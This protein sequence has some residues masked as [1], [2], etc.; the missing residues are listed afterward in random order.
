[1]YKFSIASIIKNESPY[2]LEWIAYHL[3]IGVEHFY[4]ADNCSDDGQYQ[5]LEALQ[6]LGIVTL[7]HQENLESKSA[8][9]T[10]YNK[11]IKM[12]SHTS[13]LVAFI[14]GD[15]FITIRNVERFEARLDSLINDDLCGAIAINWKTFGSSGKERFE[16]GLVIERFLHCGSNEYR[17]NRTIKT[18]SKPT[19]VKRQMIHHAIL[20]KGRYE[21]ISLDGVTFESGDRQGPRTTNFSY[22]VAQINHYVVK[23]KEEFIT[24]KMN[25]GCANRGKEKIKFLQYFNKND[26][27][28]EYCK[29]ARNLAPQVKSVINELNE[30]LSRLGYFSDFIFRFD[31]KDDVF[32]SGWIKFKDR[33]Q[34]AK[35]RV[36]IDGCYEFYYDA[37]ILRPSLL[38]SSGGSFGNYGFNFK[39]QHIP[40]KSIII[41]VKSNHSKPIYSYEKS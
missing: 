29:I 20:K 33:E 15:E 10:A 11:I 13:K 41:S 28:D 19:F 1:M 30:S 35:L 27:N 31:R 14:D 2:I 36:L 23:S 8:Q 34:S 40:E 25:R 6:D 22:D 12:T 37:N 5:L 24:K 17:G 16:E 21:H 18:I 3:S 4:I 26:V 39:L 9:V 7:F 38:E 32:F